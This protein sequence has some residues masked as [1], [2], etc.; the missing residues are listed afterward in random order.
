MVVLGNRPDRVI[1]VV[2]ENI[3]SLLIARTE[4]EARIELFMVRRKVLE[5]C[6]IK[7]KN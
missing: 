1:F 6:S 4:S 7:L 5:P 3:N 2:N